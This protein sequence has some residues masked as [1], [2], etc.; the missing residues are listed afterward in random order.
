MSQR[1][2][3]RMQSCWSCCMELTLATLYAMRPNSRVLFACRTA[4]NSSEE[5][6]YRRRRSSTSISRWRH[7][8]VA[9]EEAAQALFVIDD[10]AKTPKFE[11]RSSFSFW[12]RDLNF[13]GDACLL[14][15][16]AAKQQRSKKSKTNDRK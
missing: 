4:S 15:H 2:R 9:S 1:I 11:D 7:R 3:R 10:V 14:A 5:V 12:S 13:S 16:F 6:Q 8:W